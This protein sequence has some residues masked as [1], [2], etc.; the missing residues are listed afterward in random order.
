MFDFIPV[1]LILIFIINLYLADEFYII[2]KMKG[3]NSKK[4]FWISFFLGIAGYLLIIALPDLRRNK[5][6]DYDH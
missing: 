1:I 6:I 2:A 3:Y 4:Y 5:N